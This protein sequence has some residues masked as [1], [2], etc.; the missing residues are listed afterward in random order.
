MPEN[1]LYYVNQAFLSTV[2]SGDLAMYNHNFILGQ[3][4]VVATNQPADISSYDCAPNEVKLWTCI[5]D[6]SNGE[7]L[8]VKEKL[9]FVLRGD[10]EVFF[11]YGFDSAKEKILYSISKQKIPD[12]FVSTS[13]KKHFQEIMNEKRDI[14][15]Q[16]FLFYFLPSTTNRNESVNKCM[17]NVN[18]TPVDFDIQLIESFSMKKEKLRPELLNST[19]PAE[20]DPQVEILYKLF[21]H[22]VQYSNQNSSRNVDCLNMKEKRNVESMEWSVGSSLNK[23]SYKFLI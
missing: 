4:I 18:L 20:R 21:K 5:Y 7:F 3:L 15:E 10:E 11:S 12:T 1:T 13:F 17:G 14:E 22:I 19:N 6:L 16:S 2:K 23:N 8:G 9:A